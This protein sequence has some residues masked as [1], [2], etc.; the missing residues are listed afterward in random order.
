MISIQDTK[1]T[2]LHCNETV[3]D[4]EKAG[5]P[6]LGLLQRLLQKGGGGG[7]L[8]KEGG[9]GGGVQDERGGRA[10]DGKVAADPVPNT[11]PL[12]VRDKILTQEIIKINYG[13]WIF[14]VLTK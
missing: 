8:V 7:W 3:F 1:A 9:G 5:Y 11:F 12:L 13:Q 2:D 10:G 6:A 14:Q 4:G